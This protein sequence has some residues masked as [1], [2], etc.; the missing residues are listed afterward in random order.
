MERFVEILPE[1]YQ[2]FL[3]TILMVGIAIILAVLIGLPLG[4]LLFL[5]RNQLLLPNGPFNAILGFI[6]NVIRS[7]PFIILMVAIMPFATTITG[8]SHGPYAAS[9][10]LTL[11]AIPLFARLIETSLKEVD[12]GVIEACVAT[13]A[14]LKQIIFDVLIPE[15][16]S[17]IFQAI[18]LSII[19]IVAYSATAGVI[20][21]GGIGDLAIRYG[22]YRYDNTIMI[23]TVVIL[24]IL[25]QLIQITGDYISKTTNKQ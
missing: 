18:T 24:I 9:V 5:T 2:A 21:G 10:A 19:S 14:S 6:V 4:I 13:G 20:G 3:E 12:K 17:G 15:S 16:M 1:L 8:Q 25:V 7:F 23:V 11:A 22:Y